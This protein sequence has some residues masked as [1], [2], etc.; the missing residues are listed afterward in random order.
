MLDV[1]PKRSIDR[2]DLSLKEITWVVVDVL[3]RIAFVG[4]RL[5]AIDSAA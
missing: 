3:H 4:V 1:G 2:S 5:Y